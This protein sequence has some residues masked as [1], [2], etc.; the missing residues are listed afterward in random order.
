LLATAART[1]WFLSVGE[2]GSDGQ[3]WVKR[4]IRFSKKAVKP[5]LK[6]ADPEVWRKSPQDLRGAAGVPFG[7]YV[8]SDK[9]SGCAARAL[10]VIVRRTPPNL[11]DGVR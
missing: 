11:P 5:S 9:R 3:R 8:R 7:E 6:S 2:S 4:G 1:G 10:L